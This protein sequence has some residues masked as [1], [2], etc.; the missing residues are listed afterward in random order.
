[1]NT[2][3]YLT[4]G[5]DSAFTFIQEHGQKP[6]TLI[7]IL[8][9][10]IVE[11]DV[12]NP[13][14]L[15]LVAGRPDISGY[16]DGLGA[17]I[18][19]S[20]PWDMVQLNRNGW[21]LSDSGNN[22]LRLFNYERNQQGVDNDGAISSWSAPCDPL[23]TTS[24]V[25]H[26]VKESL[27]F[28]PRG[29]AHDADNDVIYVTYEGAYALAEIHLQSMK[30]IVRYSTDI[31]P[32][33]RII[34]FHS[35]IIISTDPQ[36]LFLSYRGFKMGTVISSDWPSNKPVVRDATKPFFTGIAVLPGLTEFVVTMSNENALVY[37][38]QGNRNML[39]MCN[40]TQGHVDNDLNDCELDSPRYVTLINDTLYIGEHGFSSGGIRT[41]RIFRG[42]ALSHV[43]CIIS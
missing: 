9:H 24:I 32:L 12:M 39:K 6:G 30:F 13:Y 5:N 19:F 27:L 17:N 23:L 10:A 31:W 38:D 18:R 3:V 20:D 41:L 16:S 37:V 14:N 29:L 35:E 1:M 8:S 33:R 15:K 25:S 11:L 40:G 34:P 2:L 28:R 21:I 36:N 22:C 26:T 7:A 4:L 42:K 43:R